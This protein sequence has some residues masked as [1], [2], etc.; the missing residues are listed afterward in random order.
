V[1]PVTSTT[2]QVPG[3]QPLA[4]GLSTSNTAPSRIVAHV[5]TDGQLLW[6]ETPPAPTTGSHGLS[7]A[8]ENPPPVLIVWESTPPAPPTPRRPQVKATP[9]AAAETERLLQDFEDSVLAWSDWARTSPTSASGSQTS[10]LGQWW[11]WFRRLL[12]RSR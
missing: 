11:Q 9:Q 2:P 6:V 7:Q 12:Q 10:A 1:P 8:A 3:S 5:G 4:S